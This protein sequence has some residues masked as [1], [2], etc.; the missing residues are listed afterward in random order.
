MFMNNA[1]KIKNYLIFSGYDKNSIYYDD[2]N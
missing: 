2:S 1:L